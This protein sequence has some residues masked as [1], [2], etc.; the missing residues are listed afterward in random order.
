MSMPSFQSATAYAPTVGYHEKEKTRTLVKF[1]YFSRLFRLKINEMNFEE[2]W[3]NYTSKDITTISDL[4][5]EVFNQSLPNNIEEGY[6]L[7]EIITEFSGHHETAKKYN[8]IE[9]FGEVLKNKQPNLYKKEGEYINEALIKYYCFTKNDEKLK[10]QIKD[11]ITREYDY[12]LVLKSIKQLLYNQYIDEVNEIIESEYKNVKESPKLIQGAEFDLAIIKY[13]IELGQLYMDQK[14][15]SNFDLTSFTDKVSQYGFNF[16]QDYCK[17][18]EIGLFDNS[19]DVLKRLLMEFPNDRSY[20]MASLE[21]K[22]LKFMQER[23]CTFPVGG[24]IWYNLFQYFEDRKTKDWQNYFKID[25]HSFRGFINSL[26]GFL[27]RNT[28][29]KAL[30]IW[31]SSYFLDFIFQSQII[32]ESNYQNQ[33]E[34]IGRIKS[35]FKEIN[36]HELWE[37]SFIHNWTPDETTNLES[38]NTERNQFESS[39][40]LDIDQ[41]EFNELKINKLFGNSFPAQENNISSPK[42][43]ERSKKIGRNEKVNVKYI[44]GTIKKDMS[45]RQIGGILK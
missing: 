3:E 33:K 9:R 39:Y 27:Y 42:P 28:I 16:N 12:D 24:K 41:E 26:S 14:D 38:W 30:V 10:V 20:I 7:G 36:K 13:Y 4:V 1:P 45:A 21:M 17:H 35:E 18:L 44:D 29:E 25:K 22:F 31:G 32:L 6:D 11:A 5:I 8:G 23:K 37:Y 19:A 34:V 2:F 40:E 15:N 43:I